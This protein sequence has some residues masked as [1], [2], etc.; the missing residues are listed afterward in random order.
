MSESIEVGRKSFKIIILISVMLNCV[1]TGILYLEMGINSVLFI[2]FSTITVLLI[3][4]F[5][6]MIRGYKFAKIIISLLF[7]FVS[8]FNT[9]R[10]VLDAFSPYGLGKDL[11]TV[12]QL[13]YA[14]VFGVFAH[15]VVFDNQ[16]K[17]YIEYKSTIKK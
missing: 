3:V 7:L 16:I 14:I 12:I 9:T 6:F 8:L 1:I 10:L 4:M 13:T 5:I 15:K 11:I 17:N 2:I